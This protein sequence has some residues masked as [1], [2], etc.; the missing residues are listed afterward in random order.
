MRM[1]DAEREVADDA[2]AGGAAKRAYVQRM[3]SDIAP[4]YDRVNRVISFRID[5]WWR[6]RAV[7]ALDVARAPAGR[8]LDLCAGTLDVATRI[9]R[10][11]GFR[12]AVLAADFA[13]PMLR[14]GLAKVR[15]GSRV[16][17]AVADA[18]A[19]PFRDGCADGAIVAFGIRNVVDLDGA[20]AE[21]YRVLAPGGRLV[22]LEFSFPRSAPV[23][24]IY[25]TY[26]N[27]VLPRVG[28][29]IARHRT[30]YDYLPRSVAH[31]PSAPE[32]ARRMRA[33]GF[34]EVRWRPVTFGVVAIHV[35]EKA[36]T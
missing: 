11:A 20:L 2:A 27:H 29:A 32:L 13:A 4:S 6:G 18:L 28:N 3:F 24:A 30:A 5:E 19:L 10:T 14:A 22:I 34:V 9:T 21:A 16:L 35:G 12:G 1:P 8:Y 36:P 15:P 31:W 26:F 7:A 33:A 17:P 25:G 23:R